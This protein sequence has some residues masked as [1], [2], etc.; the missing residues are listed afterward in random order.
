MEREDNK[1]NLANFFET[2]CGKLIFRGS[3]ARVQCLIT[4][5]GGSWR[6]NR[7]RVRRVTRRSAKK[8]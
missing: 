5:Q 8:T 2:V 6:Y 3:L 7:S 1:V 4:G